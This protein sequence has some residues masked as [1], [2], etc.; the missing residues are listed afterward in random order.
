M[1][2]KE[3][4]LQSFD[5]NKTES[6]E[7]DA[8]PPSGSPERILAEKKL[9]RK[10]D[11]RVL[12]MIILIYIMNYIDVRYIPEGSCVFFVELIICSAMVLQPLG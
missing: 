6:L 2:E 4:D 7:L 3:K 8:L 10:L 9:V 12:P 5:E 1:S 11:T